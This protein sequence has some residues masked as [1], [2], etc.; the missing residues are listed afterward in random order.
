[1]KFPKPYLP[2]SQVTWPLKWRQRFARF[3]WNPWWKVHH[4]FTTWVSVRG[5]YTF[6]DRVMW[7]I[8][9]FRDGCRYCIIDRLISNWFM[10]SS[11]KGIYG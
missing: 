5:M 8:Y 3:Y 4:F 1:M 11:G 9:M 2:K 7:R 10:F 6:M